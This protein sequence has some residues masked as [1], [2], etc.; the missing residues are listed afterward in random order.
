M[1]LLPLTPYGYYPPHAQVA[2][3]E[4]VQF[5]A[6]TIRGGLNA[7]SGGI[8]FVIAYSSHLFETRNGVS[9]MTGVF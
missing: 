3:T 5:P 7:R 4:L 2:P 8:T 9:N 6:V 1:A